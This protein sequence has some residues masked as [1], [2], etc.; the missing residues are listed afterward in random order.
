MSWKECAGKKTLRGGWCLGKGNCTS[1]EKKYPL[2]EKVCFE[3]NYRPKVGKLQFWQNLHLEKFFFGLKLT[4][5]FGGDG[6]GQ[7]LA[8]F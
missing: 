2:L 6:G 8:F 7:N 3:E 4:S 1:K 5:L